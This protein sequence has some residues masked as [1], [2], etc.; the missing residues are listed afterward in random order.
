MTTLTVALALASVA[1]GP[2]AADASSGDGGL[3]TCL[4]NQLGSDSQLNSPQPGHQVFVQPNVDTLYTM[5]HLN[6]AAGPIVLHVPRIA[7]RRYYVFQFL[8][9]YT[10]TFAYVGTR[11]TGDGAGNY[12]IT[13]PGWH[14]T[15]SKGLHQIKASYAQVWLCGRT[16]VNGPRDLAA[17]HQIQRQY[18]LIPLAQYR[19]HGLKWKPARCLRPGISGH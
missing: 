5:G 13:G 8:D 16:L 10:N 19:R 4:L 6:L 7:N 3:D 15:V 14:G 17:V 1:V 9:P 18:Q 12:L 2:A 11:T